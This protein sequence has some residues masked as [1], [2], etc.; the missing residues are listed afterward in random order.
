MDQER[1]YKSCGRQVHF[2]SFRIALFSV[3]IFAGVQVAPAND[4]IPMKTRDSSNLAQSTVTGTVTDTDGIPLAG[5]NV[6][7]KGTT[8]GTQTDFDGNYSISADT[9]AVLVFLSLI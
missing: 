5:A 1:E 4:G 7:V 3:L 9:D 8:N 6:L 2:F